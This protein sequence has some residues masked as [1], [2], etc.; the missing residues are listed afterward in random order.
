MAD[1]NN[2]TQQENTTLRTGADWKLFPGL[3]SKNK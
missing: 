2:T 3:C 1:S